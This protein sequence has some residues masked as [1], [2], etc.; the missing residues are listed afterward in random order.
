MAVV[1]YLLGAGASAE[2]VPVVNGMSKDI[3]TLRKELFGYF[4]EQDASGGF[5]IPPSKIAEREILKMLGDLSDIC[6]THY[7]IDTYAKKLYLTDRAA[8]RILKLDLSLYFTLRQ[9]INIPD[10]RYDNFFSSIIT[11]ENKLPANIKLISWN[12]D[13]QLERSFCEFNPGITLDRS[14]ELLGITAPN[15]WAELNTTKNKFKTLKLNGSARLSTDDFN[16]YLFSSVNLPTD[17]LISEVVN[18]YS[19]MVSRADLFECEMKFA[20]EGEHYNQLFESASRDLNKI[21]VLVVIGY[22]FPFFNREVDVALFRNMQRLKKVYIQDKY[23]EDIKETMTEIID[24]TI[25]QRPPSIILKSNL[26]QFVF[27]KELDV[28]SYFGD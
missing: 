9:L 1:G 26:K 8:F 19:E 25:Y 5:D 16:G 3:E 23:P 4:C 14:R 2:C 17:E 18:K 11:N 20:W 21:E 24:P 13:F 6:E 15:R 10:K 12:Y 7:S 28:T 22:S 27:P